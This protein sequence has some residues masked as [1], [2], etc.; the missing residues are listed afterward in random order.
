MTG[1]NNKVVLVFGATGKVGSTAAAA[2]LS[3][4]ADV[5]I[6]VRDPAKPLPTSALQSA[7]ANSNKKHKADLSDPASVLAAT[8]ASGATA[9]FVYALHESAD[10]MRAT[11]AALKEGGIKHVVL[12]SSYTLGVS[13]EA[14]AKIDKNNLD[15][16]QTFHAQAEASIKA[17]GFESRTFVRPGSFASNAIMWWKPMIADPSGTVYLPFPD[18]LVAHI[19]DNDIGDV[20]GALLVAD[21]PTPEI[22]PLI[23]PQLVSHRDSVAI[24]G[25]AIGRELKV[26][27][28]SVEQYRE[29]T[30]K[31]VPPPLVD[32]LIKYWTA[33]VA[34]PDDTSLSANVQ[35]YAGRP[36]MTFEQWVAQHKDAFN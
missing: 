7:F 29:T 18:A 31:F 20:A 13:K 12:L 34:Q 1:T 17:V 36:A 27:P 8:R 24:I 25:K 9:A 32:A 22:V 26:V 4:G 5:H 35:R 3:R 15:F 28:V 16:I 10:G 23:G 33:A 30:I 19:V 21:T 14:E 2:A 6:A 11:F